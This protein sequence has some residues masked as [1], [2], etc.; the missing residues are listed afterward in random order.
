MK[1][2]KYIIVNSTRFF[3]FITFILVIISLIVSLVFNLSKAHS[4]S[5][6]QNYKVYYVA[7]GDNLWDISLRNMP[8]D[9]D[10]RRMVY[11]I[12]KLNDME[13]SYI[14]EGDSIKIP[15]YK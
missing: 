7:K 13:T 6:M 11:E 4:S 2:K 10:V 15:T 9:F 14:Y 12:K 5:Y 1:D 3:I 8:K